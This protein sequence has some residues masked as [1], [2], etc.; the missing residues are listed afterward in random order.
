MESADLGRLVLLA[1]CLGLSAFFSSSETAFIALPRARLYH[2]VNMGRANARLVQRMVS[3]P[4]RLLATVLL[5]N[6]LV[7]TAA[8]SLGTAIAL[9]L[10]PD[11]PSL[12]VLLATVAVTVL[13]LVFSETLPKTIAWNRP[14]TLVFAYVRPLH[15]AELLLAPAVH[16]L[17][18]I[19]NAV[20]SVF[21]I[22]NSS[23]DVSEA[24]IR[25][26]IRAGAQTGAVEQQEA[27]LLDKVFRFGDQQLQ[28]IMTPRTEVVWVERG[29][30]LE[31]FLELYTRHS[32]TRFPVYEQDMENVVGFLSSKDV[33]LALGSG[34]LQPGDSVTG[35]LREAYFVLE[36]RTVADTFSQMQSDGHGLA[37]AIDEFGGISG[38]VTMKQ[39]L[40]VIVGQVDEERG[41]SDTEYTRLDDHT[42]RLNAGLSIYQANE[43]LPLLGL[44]EGDYQTV[45][46]FILDRL[47]FIPE[48][49]EILEFRNL[50]FK[51]RTM[52][53]LRIEEV[54]VHVAALV[55]DRVKE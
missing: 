11:N 43:A 27:D 5:S 38:L 16:I 49:G 42:F 3:R 25:S 1:L 39:M 31:R 54:E 53:G 20:T 51:I 12:A 26:L 19:T 9:S 45:A 23:A 32:H 35:L 37:L 50:S 46:G 40:E 21:G 34:D 36:T 47:G 44:P 17:Q 18:F 4:E 30:T 33:L 41:S 2:L 15:L 13:L 28:E 14:E 7:N 8:A 24:E 22:T 52:N 48:A 29:T 10:L 55:E 6:N